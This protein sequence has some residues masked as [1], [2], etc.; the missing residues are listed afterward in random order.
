MAEIAIANEVS[1]EIC[2][3]NDFYKD[4]IDPTEAARDKMTKKILVCPVG[5]F[6][7]EK[8]II[9]NDIKMRFDEI[10]V[11]VKQIETKRTIC[12]EFKG[13]IVEISQVN[14]NR[15]WGRRLEITNC[16]VFRTRTIA[17]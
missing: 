17:N 3:D 5:K 11:T 7:V 6:K 15:I 4:D 13:C 12:G 2:P 1:D 16:S 14:L 9:D 10:G 8:E